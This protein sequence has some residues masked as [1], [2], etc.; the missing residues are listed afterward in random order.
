MSVLQDFDDSYQAAYR[1]WQ[2]WFAEAQEDLAYYVGDQWTE[3]EKRYLR[4]QSRSALVFN[5][6]RQAIHQLEGY[7]RQHR[8][9]SIAVGV[10]E[11]D[12]V[13]S[14]QITRLIMHGERMSSRYRVLSES[15]S[16]ALKVG[17]DLPGVWV[18]YRNDMVNGDIRYSRDPW[19]GWIVDPWFTKL[20]LSDAAYLMRRRYIGKD[21][22]MSLLPKHKQEVERLVDLKGSIDDKFTWLPYSRNYQDNDMVAYTEYWKKYWKKQPTLLNMETGEFQEWKGTRQEFKAFQDIYPEHELIERQVQHVDRTVIVN[23]EELDTVTDPDGLNDYPFNPV[24]GYYQP[25]C[26]DNSRRLQGVIRSMRDPQ[27]EY[28][29]RRCQIIDF[30]DS[31]INSGMIAEEDAAIDNDSLY[32]TGQ[33]KVIFAR[34]GKLGAIQQLRTEDIPQSY[35]VNTEVLS[36]DL[37]E[38]GGLNDA[39]FGIAESG[40]ETGITTMLRQ[41]AAL[42]SQQNLLDNLREAQKILVV[43]EIKLMQ[44]WTPEKIERI[45]GEPPAPELFDREVTKWDISIQ[46]GVLTDTQ[47]QMHFRQL[48]DLKN[49]GEPIAPGELTD[50]APLQGKPAHKRKIKEAQEAQT[51]AEQQQAALESELL[52]AQKDLAVSQTLLNV[53]SAKEKEARAQS[54]MGLEDSRAAEAVESRSNAALDQVKAAKEIQ[55]MELENIRAGLEI[56]NSL[57][58]KSEVEEDE[59]KLKNAAIASN[60]VDNSKLD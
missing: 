5:K 57:I 21:L 6:T 2:S 40:N 42:T 14:D 49:L 45:L 56:T 46:E 51:Q 50:A 47:R 16:G 7:Q 31:K 27:N 44:Q 33:G 19:N 25:D 37:K 8:L 23:N 12:D 1:V 29:R 20:D 54:N 15:Y 60:G 35:F 55:G 9:S 26:D 48:I 52:Q 59:I 34:K 39:A 32:Q 24:L 4:E 43:K 53:S 10:E 30:A 41:S 17:A 22:A 3:E 58:E 36:Q 13:V 18:D 28:N 11:G 38:L